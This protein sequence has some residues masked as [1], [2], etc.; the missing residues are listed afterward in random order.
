MNFIDRSVSYTEVF[1]QV[2]ANRKVL[3]YWQVYRFYY[4]GTIVSA[5]VTPLL[6]FIKI[7][8]NSVTWFRFWGSLAVMSSFLLVSKQ[9]FGILAFLFIFLRFSDWVD[10]DIA[11]YRQKSSFSGRYTECLIDLIIESLLFLPLSYFLFLEDQN[12]VWFW[13]GSICCFIT[14]LA[15]LNIDRYSAFRR[16]IKEE[17]GIDIGTHELPP[18]LKIFRAVYYDLWYLSLLAIAWDIKLGIISLLIIGFIGNAVLFAYHFNLAR[19]NMHSV[20]DKP[21]HDGSGKRR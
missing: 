20:P 1:K 4:I 21:K 19:N 7:S 15:N 14:L 5:I 9:Y 16:W 17:Q 12:P 13:A 6:L 2:K 8:A 10:G 11:R 3:N 18:S